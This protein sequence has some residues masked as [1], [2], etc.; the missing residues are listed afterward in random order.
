MSQPPRTDRPEMPGGYLEEKRLPWAWA[1]QRLVAARNYWVATV[2]AADSSPSI[3][4]S[5]FARKSSR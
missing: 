1:E 2:T 3:T 4:T 5:A